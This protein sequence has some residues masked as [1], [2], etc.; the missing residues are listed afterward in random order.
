MRITFTCWVFA[1]MLVIG[2]CSDMP[3][4]IADV[5]TV[6]SN[7]NG[8]SDEANERPVTPELPETP[9]MPEVPEDNE[10]P[11]TPVLPV[12]P[13]GDNILSNGGFEQWESEKP[14]SWA[15]F[16]LSN[17]VIGQSDDAKEGNFSVY[18]RNTSKQRLIS[19]GYSLEAGTYSF[20]VHVKAVDS[21][22]CNCRLGYVPVVNGDVSSVQFCY[23]SAAAYKVAESW[24]CRIYEFGLERDMDV[25]LVISGTSLLVDDARLIRIK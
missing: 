3:E 12:L 21:D 14:V 4:H 5:P 11:E 9:D 25:A 10:I 20:V 16:V 23:E 17:A 24:S 8:N 15:K 1:L 18:L 19:E 7:N 2:V 13:E 6:G 22:V